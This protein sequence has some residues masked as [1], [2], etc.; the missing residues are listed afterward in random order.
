M[1]IFLIL[2]DIFLNFGANIIV[3]VT[4]FYVKSQTHKFKDDVYF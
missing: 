1:Q 4:L 3:F 2:Q